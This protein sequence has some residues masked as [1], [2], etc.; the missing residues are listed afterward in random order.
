[1]LILLWWYDVHRNLIWSLLWKYEIYNYCTKKKPFITYILCSNK[2]ILWWINSQ[3]ISSLFRIPQTQFLIR[4]INNIPIYHKRKNPLKLLP[5]PHQNKSW[6]TLWLSILLH[7]IT[8]TYVEWYWR[9]RYYLSIGSYLSQV[10]SSRWVRLSSKS[11]HHW[12]RHIGPAASPSRQ[13]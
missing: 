7:L 4:L 13:R 3:I 5:L 2:F 11:Q 9:G 10:R 12:P 6:Y 8:V 1:M